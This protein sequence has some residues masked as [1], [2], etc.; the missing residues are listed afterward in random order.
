LRARR[1]ATQT[2]P[3]AVRLDTTKM[4]FEAAFIES[5]CVVEAR[6]R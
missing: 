5:L 1:R 6:R 2:R 4:S 3:S